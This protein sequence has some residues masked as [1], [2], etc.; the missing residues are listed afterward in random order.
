MGRNDSRFTRTN[1]FVTLWAVIFMGMMALFISLILTSQATQ[2]VTGRELVSNTEHATELLKR[3][4]LKPAQTK[5]DRRPELKRNRD[6][7]AGLL[8]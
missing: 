3:E 1:G 2:R 6:S 7:L 5:Q 4:H 8:E